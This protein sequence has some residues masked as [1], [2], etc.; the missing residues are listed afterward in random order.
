[1]MRAHAAARMATLLFL[2]LTSLGLAA[3]A[4]REVTEPAE[5]AP[6]GAPAGTSATVRSGA[7]VVSTSFTLPPLRSLSEVMQRPLFSQTRRPPPPEASQEEIKQT[8][9][10]VLE[11]IVL[12]SR[13]RTA[14]IAH[15]RPPTLTRVPEGQEIEGWTVLTI[16]PDLVV[17]QRG[18]TR[19]E[20]K[21]VDKTARPRPPNAPRP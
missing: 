11:G 3:I 5:T 16:Q 2:L 21:L 19:Q 10:L 14:L 8:S 7:A 6:E 18:A 12:S 17:L 15:G 4:S 20:L 9:T 1:M 13:D